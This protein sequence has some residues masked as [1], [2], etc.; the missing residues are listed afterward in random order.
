MSAHSYM[1]STRRTLRGPSVLPKTQWNRA[2]LLLT[3]FKRCAE[4]KSM[5]I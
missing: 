5:K 2:V 4:E 3:R 1:R